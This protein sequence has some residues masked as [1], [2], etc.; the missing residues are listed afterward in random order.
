M[1]LNDFPR[2]ARDSLS[3][4]DANRASAVCGNGDPNL[5]VDKA[6][7]VST[8]FPMFTLYPFDEA[9]QRKGC[10]LTNDSAN[11]TFMAV[12]CWSFPL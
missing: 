1:L 5:S 3:W 9:H 7:M 10:F 12:A 6:K 4:H 2:S 8:S 11:A